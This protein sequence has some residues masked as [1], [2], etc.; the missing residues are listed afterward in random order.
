MSESAY[1]WLTDVM[2]MAWV[3]PDGPATE[4]E[5][6]ICHVIGDIDE[7]QG[8]VTTTLC[9]TADGRWQTAHRSQAAP[10]S[11][12]FSLEVWLAKT[13]TWL[14]KLKKRRCPFPVYIMH[15][16]CPPHDVFLNYD[17]GQVMHWPFITSRGK[18][19]VG[20]QRGEEGQAVTQVNQTY[21]MSAG[22]NAPEV[23]KLTHTR[24]SITE[25]E[26]LRDI[27]FCNNAR[28]VGGCG[29][30]E[31]ECKDG[32]IVCDEAALASADVWFTADYGVTWTASTTQPFT[33]T[34]SV[35][36]CV[37]FYTGRDAVRHVVQRGTADAAAA[38]GEIAYTDDAGATA[39]TNVNVGAV[40]S[41]Y[42][43]HSGGL[44][45]LDQNHIWCGTDQGNIYFS[46]DAA[47]TWVDQAAPD[48]AAGVQEIY[49]IHFTDERYGN[50]VGDAR[51]HVYTTDGG[52]HWAI[53]AHTEGADTD[54]YT[55]VATI[56]RNRAFIG[57]RNAAATAALFYYTD[58]AGVTLTSYLARLQLAVDGG[59]ITH[60]G[61][62]MFCDEFAGAVTG[63]W[64]DGSDDYKVTWRT[65]NGGWDWE[66][67]Y[68]TDD[69]FDTTTQEYQG[70]NACWICNYNQIWSVGEVSDSTG[71]VEE[72]SPLGSV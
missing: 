22:P 64:N 6:L 9:R 58:D 65:F 62:V 49:Y 69:A 57:G 29:D 47:V 72:L 54:I 2:G 61:D 11:V 31:D 71:A 17:V 4:C 43:V 41:E 28:C 10:S 19:N 45:A 27:A 39:W 30:L 50:A 38:V 42:G 25:D 3:Q 60:I 16:E 35:N 12:T 13:R 5:P 56:D 7:P 20:L 36:S 23:W 26:P 44:F 14:Q 70:G 24:R 40:A 46:S 63:T 32:I 8:D 52:T 34:E 21:E 55:C 18:S 33:T 66:A 15:S 1:E 53:I 59:T 67:Y 68:S 37:C 48:P 51:H